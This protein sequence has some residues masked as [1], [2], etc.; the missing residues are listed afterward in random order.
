MIDQS[1]SVDFLGA[2]LSEIFSVPFSLQGSHHPIIRLPDKLDSLSWA[3]P[4]T[5]LGLHRNPV[6]VSF[7]DKTVCALSKRF[8]ATAGSTFSGD[9]MR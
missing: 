9:I 3:D 4:I 6:V 7:L 2:E 5:K 8:Y 1:R